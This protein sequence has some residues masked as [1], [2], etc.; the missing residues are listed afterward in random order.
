MNRKRLGVLGALTAAALAVTV[1]VVPGAHAANEIVIWADETRGPHLASVFAAKGDW[2][3]GYTIK[4]VSFS[5]YD[6]LGA[7]FDKTSGTTGPD[8]LVAG[9]DW[10]VASAKSGK[11]APVT[12]TASQKSRFTPSQFYDL[13]YRGKLYGIPVDVNNVSMIYNTKLVKT[14]PTSFGEMV[15]FYKANKTA[16]GL[17]AGLCISGGGM[18]WGGLSVFSALGANPYQM[19][20][21]RPN[22][23]YRFNPAVF[24]S[25]VKTYLLDANGKSNGFY[26]A[27]DT[28]CMDNFLAG[29]VPYSVIGNW[30][31][32][33]F[34]DKGFAMNLMPVP[35]VKAGSYG[36]MFGSVS[37]AFLTAYADKHGV[38]VGAKSLLVN[39]F[40]STAGQVAYEALEG[41]PP[42]EKGA[43]SSPLVSD[44]Q[45]GFGQAAGLSSMPQIG[46]FL[47]NN[48][49]GANYW[50]SSGAYWTA[51]LV[52]GKNPLVEA[53]KL[54][55]MWA[56]NVAAGKGDL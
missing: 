25:N 1:A 28:G 5:S 6:A 49:G 16:L 21:G 43:Q 11:L 46:A 4:V 33:A 42:A 9:N 34:A 36:Q 20:R 15:N 56:K 12:L 52:N 19:F 55:T 23:H 32:K 45:K 50:D 39:F 31:W 27:T 26:P 53:K 14:A 51:V 17:K 30:H 7:A 54:S 48:S 35:G 13:S 3:P 40:A 37:G 2:V 41:R 18:A 8:I 47:G 44:A 22:Y 10:V 29:T 24:A 38:A